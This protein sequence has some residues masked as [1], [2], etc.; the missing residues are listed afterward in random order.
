MSRITR[1]FVSFASS[2]RPAC[3]AVLLAAATVVVVGCQGANSGGGPATAGAPAKADARPN[4]TV[5]RQGPAPLT[6]VFA[7]GGK[8]QIVDTTDN[9]VLLTTTVPPNSVVTLN[10]RTG[11]TV[12]ARPTSAKGP[13]GPKHRFEFR[14][15]Q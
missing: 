7:A 10:T 11:V 1:Q 9:K 13:L 15:M 6:N 3:G 8:I 2:G 12:N 4:Y 14:L 5:V